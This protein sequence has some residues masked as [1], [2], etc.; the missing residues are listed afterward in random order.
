MKRFLFLFTLCCLAP[1]FPCAAA[2]TPPAVKFPARDSF[3]EFY[4]KWNDTEAKVPGQYL[5]LTVSPA[6]LPYPLLHYRLN[7]HVTEMEPGNA[8][9]LY[10]EAYKK[11]RQTE[12]YALREMYRSEE[13]ARTVLAERSGENAQDDYA[14]EKM[15][16]RAFPIPPRYSPNAWTAIDASQEE[17]LYRSLN[18]AFQLLEKASKK[19]DCD[20]SYL[21]EFKGFATTLEHI[22]DIRDLGRYLSGKAN[23]EIRNGKYEEAVRTIRVGYRLAE[24]L[25]NSEFP[26]LVTLLVSTAIRGTM[27]GQLRLLSVQPDAPNLYP[28]LTQFSPTADVMMRKGL[29]AEQSWVFTR[30]NMIQAFDRLDNLPAEECKAVLREFVSLFVS[31][32]FN[33]LEDVGK[34][35][36]LENYLSAACL[37]S[38][39]YGK[40]RL[41]KRGLSEE[42]IGKLSVY[43]VVTPYLLESTKAA[44]EKMLVT[45]SFP[46]GSQHTAIVFDD[47]DYRRFDSPADLYLSL[48]LPAVQA[49]KNAFSRTDQ[50]TD[51]MR[52]VE[53]IRYY[54]ATHDGKLPKS[55][56]A[57]DQ[58]PVP[59]VGVYDNK[60]FRYHVE[61]DTAVIEYAVPSGAGDSRMEVTVERK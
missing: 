52:I 16:F 21:L 55:L 14:A 27:D 32:Q 4:E 24:H 6:G 53:V 41:L 2:D 42:E 29:Q 35:A 13:Y 50:N 11:M 7:V 30:P 34:S 46:A 38:Y 59:L 54:A 26:C 15:N 61:G 47:Y 48:I 33:S 37:I 57:V 58:L 1:G 28:A 10:Q 39:P 56:D 36:D 51:L 3:R 5:R 8:A 49:A 19:R 31:V 23:W 40:E 9:P 12:Y 60:P 25:G 22:Q 18:P 44:Y 45:A 17:Q 20:W 43:Q